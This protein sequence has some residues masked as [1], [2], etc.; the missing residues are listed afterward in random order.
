MNI[1][2]VI[3]PSILI[4]VISG[5]SN[6]L[7]SDAYTI[8]FEIYEIKFQTIPTVCTIELDTTNEDR[9]DRNKV[10]RMLDEIKIG[11][12]E[13]EVKL[14][15]GEKR[16]SKHNWEINYQVIP[17]EKQEGYNYDNCDVF[18]SFQ[19]KPADKENWIK[20]L[21]ITE[22]E[23]GDTGRTNIIIYYADVNLCKTEDS[24]WYYYDPC[25]GDGA[26][27]T[28]Q[29]GTV[30][31]HEF[32]HAMGLGHY[33]ADELD[34]NV[35]WAKGTSTSQSIMTIFSH[36]NT[37]ENTIKTIDVQKVRELYG[38]YGFLQYK[39]DEKLPPFESFETLKTQ[40]LLP[41]DQNEY[42]RIIGNITKDY[43]KSGQPV[44]VTITSP[45]GSIQ[46]IQ[47]VMTS[48]NQ[49]RTH[50]PLTSGILAGTYKIQASY[51]NYKS[52]EIIVDVVYSTENGMQ[53]ANKIPL[54]VKTTAKFW[55]NGEI[56]D[57]DFIQGIQYLVKNDIIKI[58]TPER[59]QQE[60]ESRVPEWVKTST[61]W[62]VNDL[63]E[64]D[65]FVNGI[66]FLIQM[67]IVIV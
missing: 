45:D 60:K 31:R 15:Q 47:S 17:L 41:Q 9:I 55:T 18:I 58:E 10:K 1:K 46:Q 36:E 30:A 53:L 12:N 28:R 34:V 44:T 20:H 49:F 50:F 64:E 37:R 23:V 65:E 39:L 67:G 2:Y 22:F 4:L 48:D 52:D 66:Q 6:I 40:Y 13:W 3:I 61:E 27:T 63:I 21:G 26:R 29:I 11:I 38:E 62:W 42:V 7:E 54:W 25:Y 56:S 51:T 8:E 16:I 57:R 32:G 24:Q 33:K 59:I 43:Y 35:A 14:K 5:F 19:D